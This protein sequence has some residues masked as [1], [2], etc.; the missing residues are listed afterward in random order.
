[1]GV[2]PVEGWLTTNQ[3]AALTGYAPAY[4]RVLAKQGKVEGFKAGRDWLV[5]R[6]SVLAYKAQMDR[7]G[8]Q[9]HNPRREGQRGQERRWGDSDEVTIF[10][11]KR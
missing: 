7:L 4:I 1:M 9:K 10:T 6:E 2:K 3:A 11:E 8:P 5:S